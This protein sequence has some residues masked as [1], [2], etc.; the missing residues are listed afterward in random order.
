MDAAAVLD[1]YCEHLLLPSR[2]GCM[3]S[4]RGWRSSSSPDMVVVEALCLV[5]LLGE[6]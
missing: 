3:L 4:H 5:R 1:T 6:C 2:L